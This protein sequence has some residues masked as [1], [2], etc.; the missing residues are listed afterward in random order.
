M[1]RTFSLLTLLV[2]L[3]VLLAACSPA[4]PAGTTNPVPTVEA[5]AAPVS[6]TSTMPSEPTATQAPQ[7]TGTAADQ[8]IA[9]EDGTGNEIKLEKPAERVISL[10]PAN[11]EI[12]FALGAGS[13]VIAREDF[14]NYPEEAAEL[15]S[16]GGNMGEY[17]LE[18]IARLQPDLILASPLNPPETIESLKKITPN[19]FVVANPTTLEE[20]YENLLD[21]G[22]LTG[23]EEEAQALV[24]DLTGRVQVVEAA[25]KDVTKKP[26]VFYELDA[27]DP[28][29]P[30][31]SGPGT[32]VDM[33]ITKAGGQNIGASLKGEWAQISQEELVVQNPDL[34]LLGDSLYGGIT[35]ESV[36]ARPGWGG[37]AA[38]ANK[39]VLPFNDDLVSRPGP[40]MVQG[41]EE[42]AKAIHPELFD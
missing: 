16:I 26:K 28:A 27:T 34:I 1:K 12:L 36:A 21:V 3:A 7:A 13:Q 6:P 31:T 38:V 14:S 32:F 18:E 42:L 9:L 24:A 5:T 25:L 4:A 8:G 29:K 40:R 23:R 15:P 30:W 20:L 37:I 41:L 22:V 19:V 2:I 11:T 35:P 39:R 33:L 17:G 10:A